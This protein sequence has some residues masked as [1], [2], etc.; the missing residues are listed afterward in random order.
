M[1]ASLNSNL[2]A[3]TAMAAMGAASAAS[4]GTVIVTNVGVGNGDYGNVNIGPYGDPWTTPILLTDSQG[5]QIVVFCDD[6]QHDVNVTSYNPGL[7]Y[8]TGPVKF[9]GFGDPLTIQTSN[10]MGQLAVIGKLDYAHGNED[11]AIAA[12]AAIWDIEYGVT[13]SSSDSTVQADIT[14][15]LSHLHY[16][17]GGWATGL[18]AQGFPGAGAT[19]SFVTGVPE[20]AT[21][22]MMILGLGLVGVAARRRSRRAAVAA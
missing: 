22:A 1:K 7:T 21:W 3:V 11:G 10:E 19:Q 2:L 6:L 9:D 18:I 15:L 4:A 13:A 17:G 5:H 16:N 14:S 12:Q 20:P 8:A